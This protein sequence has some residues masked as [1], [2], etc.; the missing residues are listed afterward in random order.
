MRLWLSIIIGRM[1]TAQSQW[2][3]FINSRLIVALFSLFVLVLI[4]T[5]GYSYFEGWSLFDALYAT[6]ITITTVGY[7]DFSPQTW[8]GRLF[9]IIFT[10]FAIGLAGYALSTLAVIMIENEKTRLERKRLERKMN[11]IANL[12]DHMIVCGGNILAHRAANEFFQRQ[13]PFVFIEQNEE[14]LKWA[15]LWMHEGYV[16]KRRRHYEKLDEVDLTSE[17]QKSVP[18][19]ADELGVLY[20]LADPTDEQQLRRAGIV[21]ARGVVA[22]LNDDRDN[23]AIVLS[24]RDMANRLDNPGLRIIARVV[25][26]SNMHRLYLAGAD[27]VIAPN[28]SGGFQIATDM[29]HPVVGEFWEK[30]QRGDNEFMRFLDIDLAVHPEWVGQKAAALKEQQSQLVV[31]IKRDGQFIYMPSPDDVLAANDVLIVMGSAIRD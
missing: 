23:M 12:R 18:E 4:G 5:A 1:E 29:L 31:A 27:R 6:A 20:L 7:G 21:K 25:N 13:I 14:T 2:D 3:R 8:S 17:E 16:N 9:S 28:M 26:E 24:A 30:I 19:L 15:L 11:G 10:F 22:A